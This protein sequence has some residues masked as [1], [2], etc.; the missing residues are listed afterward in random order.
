MDAFKLIEN[1][2]AEIACNRATAWVEGKRVVIA[3]VIGDEMVLT[4]AGLALAAEAPASAPKRA[5][6][7]ATAK[8]EPATAVDEQTDD[9]DGDQ[10]D[11]GLDNL[12]PPTGE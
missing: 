1:T 10:L 7:K 11:F 8:P 12:T 9:G 3:E 4:E 5:P 6:K 2:K